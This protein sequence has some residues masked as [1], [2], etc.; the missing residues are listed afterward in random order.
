M[1]RLRKRVQLEAKRVRHFRVSVEHHQLPPTA[2]NLLEQQFVAPTLNRIWVGDIT[3]VAT[4][5][6]W[7]YVAVLLDLCSRRVIGMGHAGEA[8]PTPHVGGARDGSPP[9]TGSTWFNPSL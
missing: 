6:G 5:A 3:L 1:A 8:G 7:L 9:A 4:R 2:P